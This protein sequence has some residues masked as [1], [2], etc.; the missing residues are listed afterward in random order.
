MQGIF[1]NCK[2]SIGLVGQLNNQVSVQRLYETAIDNS[3]L[4]TFFFQFL[5]RLKRWQHPITYGENGQVFAFTQQLPFA[6]W[7]RLDLAVH[8]HPYRRAPGVAQGYGAIMFQGGFQHPLQ[9]IFI[10]RGH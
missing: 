8:G 7:K 6:N 4:D 9:F 2:Q 1:F 5:G 10:G 3:C